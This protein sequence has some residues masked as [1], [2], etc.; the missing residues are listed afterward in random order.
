MYRGGSSA[1]C[2]KRKRNVVRGEGHG[3]GIT[4]CCRKRLWLL[5]GKHFT[6]AV[7][8]RGFEN[9]WSA[10]KRNGVARVQAK[11]CPERCVV[12]QSI[13]NERR[14]QERKVSRNVGSANFWWSTHW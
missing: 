6:N 10:A 13:G 4:A 8:E 11:F 3:K 2:W 5:F 1:I 14:L 12:E 9:G 7:I